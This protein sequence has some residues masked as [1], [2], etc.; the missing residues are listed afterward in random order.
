MLLTSD[1]D[2]SNWEVMSSVSSRSDKG[3]SRVMTRLLKQSKQLAMVLE[4]K[5]GKHLSVVLERFAFCVISYSG[6][7]GVLSITI[8]LQL[9]HYKVNV[10]FTSGHRVVCSLH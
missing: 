10:L 8:W 3:Y 9:L 1:K 4:G 7:S 5:V 2:D 6:F